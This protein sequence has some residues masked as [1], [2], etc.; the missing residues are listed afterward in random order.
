MVFTALRGAKWTKED[1]EEEDQVVG[2]KV[3]TMSCPWVG[4]IDQKLPWSNESIQL[5][6]LLLTESLNVT[7]TNTQSYMSGEVLTG[8]C[9]SRTSIG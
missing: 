1:L 4:I 2:L 7:V 3:N 8:L 9:K 5:K 6:S